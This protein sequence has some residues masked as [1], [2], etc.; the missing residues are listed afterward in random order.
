VATDQANARRRAGDHER[1]R[2]VT[3]KARAARTVRRAAVATD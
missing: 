3:V 2:G 1:H